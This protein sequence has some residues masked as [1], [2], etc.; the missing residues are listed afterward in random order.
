MPSPFVDVIPPTTIKPAALGEVHTLAIGWNGAVFTFTVDGADTVVDPRPFQAIGKATP[1][2]PDKMLGGLVTFSGPG[3]EAA[4]AGD[5][6]NVY[7]NGSLY[8]DFDGAPFSGPRLDPT[9]WGGDMLEHVRES[10]GGRLVSKAAAAG[11][12]GNA[13]GSV[14]RFVNQNAVT[15]IRADVTVTEFQST[16]SFA[17]AR[18][19][20]SVYNDGTGTPDGGFTGDVAGYLRLYSQNGSP[21]RV[22]FLVY[23]CTNAQCSAGTVLLDNTGPA[24][25]LGQT[26]TLLL[27]WDGSVFTYGI[28]GTP[29][30]F[31]PKPAVPPVKPPMGHFKALESVASVETPGGDGYIA[32]TYDNVYVNDDAVAVPQLAPFL[33]TA[34]AGDVTSAGVGLRGTGS[35]VINLAGIPAGATVQQ[36][37]LYWA[38]LGTAGT[39]TAPTL[40]GTAVNGT[41]IGR[42]DDTFWG[43]FQNY[44]YRADVT[45]LI[46]GNGTYTVSGLP[47]AGPT[48]NDSQGASL[49][50][51]YSVP[52]APNRHIHI[53]EGAV[54]LAGPRLAYYATRMSGLAAPD[55]PTGTTLTFLVGD[56]Q[57]YTGDS[58]GLNATLVATNGFNGSN[59]TYWDTRSYDVSG[60]LAGGATSADVVVS[61][62]NDSLVWVAAI[63][64]VPDHPQVAL[65]VSK[66]G[67]GSGTVTSDPAGIACGSTCSASFDVGT[68]VTLTAAALAGS[69]FAG[70]S[71]EGCSG[72][73]TCTVAVDQARHVTGTF[74]SASAIPITFGQTVA[75]SISSAGEQ[76]SY[77]FAAAAGDKVLARITATAGSLQPVLRLYAP[78]GTKPCEA[79]AYPAPTG[80]IASCAIPTAGTYTLLALDRL[81]TGTGS[82]SLYLQRLNGPGSPTA[83]TFGQTAAGTLASATQ[84]NTYA[85][86]AA[87]GDKVLARIT[88]TAGSLQ[89]VLRLYG[90]DGSKLCEAIAYPAPTGEIASCAIPT[91]GTYTLLALDRLGT[92]TGSYSLYLQRLNGPGSPTALTFGQTAAGTLASATQMNTYAFSAAAGDK[93]LARITATAGSLQPVLRLYAPDGSLVN[94]ATAYPAPTAELIVTL[95]TAGTYTLL[96]LDRLGTGTGS[97]SL[98]LQRLNGPGSPTPIVVGQTLS[99]S[100]ASTAE[101]NAF[102]FSVAA[103][104]TVLVRITATTGSLQ[105]VLRLYAPDGSLVNEATAYPAPT[106][107]LIVTLPTAGTYTLLALDRLGTGTGSYSLYLQRLNGP[108]SPTP[109]VVGQTLSSS[110]ASTAE[111][112]AFTFS[113][114]A[115][116]KVLARITATAGSLQPVLRLYAPDGSLVNEAT[117]YPAP[118]AELIVTL[119]TAGTYTLLALDRLG[120]GTGSYSLYLQRLNGPGSPTALTF[121]QTAAGTLASATQMNTYAFSAAAGDKVL[122]R[123][124]ATAGSLQP[125]LRLYGP[126][127]SKLCEAIA[128]PAPTGEIASCAIPTSGTYTLLALDRLGTGTGSYS[129]YLQRLNGPGSPTPIVVGQTLSSSI[130][131]TAEMNAFT[132]SVAANDTV[133]VRMTQTAGTLQPVVR[134]YGPDGSKLCEATAYPAPTAEIASCPLPTA[135]TYTLLALDRLGTGTGGY[136]LTLQNLEFQISTIFPNGGG[137]AG[138]VSVAINGHQLWPGTMVRLRRVGYSDILGVPVTVA[139]NGESLTTTFDLRGAEPGAWDV[140][141]TSADSKSATLPNGFTVASGGE[142]RLWAEV[143]AAPA[144]RMG[145][146]RFMVSYGNS[147]NIDSPYAW[148]EIALPGNVSYEV[149]IPPALTPIT[150]LGA[151]PAGTLKATLVHLS[152]LPANGTGYV[153]VKI[154]PAAIGQ[155]IPVSVAIEPR[156]KTYL[157]AITALQATNALDQMVEP[158]VGDPTVNCLP[159]CPDKWDRPEPPPAGYICRWDWT[160]QPGTYAVDG[161]PGTVSV[162]RGVHYAKSLGGNQVIEMWRIPECG[163]P[164][165]RLNSLDASNP[166]FKGCFKP[167]PGYDQNH[168]NDVLQRATNALA[169]WGSGGAQ[170]SDKPCSYLANNNT[171]V[172]DCIGFV[173]LLEKELIPLTGLGW[174]GDILAAIDHG[175]SGGYV[176]KLET[177]VSTSECPDAYERMINDAAIILNVVG[178]IDPNSKSGAAGYGPARFSSSGHG[179]SYLINFEN[180]AVATAPAQEVVITDQLDPQKV[181]FATFALGPIRF[182]T[183]EIV[184][185]RGLAL[186]YHDV[187]LRPG[188]NLLVRIAASLD[189]TNGLA[190]WRFTSI[191]P[192]TGLPPEDP[193]AGFLP[194]NMNSPEGEGSVLFTIMPKAGLPTGTE[195]R[196]KASIV[197]D[198]NAPI[199]TP[200]WLNTL[201]ND[202]PSSQVAA[203]PAV[204]AVTS[205]EVQW[206]GSDVGAGVKDYTIFVSENGGAFTEWLRNTT[207][208]SATF[209]GQPG[210]SYAFYSVARDQAGNVEDAPT[211]PDAT[212][213]IQAGVSLT[214]TTNPGGRQI[215][216]D[217]QSYTAPQT[218]TWLAGA[219]H[220]LGALSP[221]DGPAGTRYVF[222][223]WSDGGAQTHDVTVPASG[224]TVTVNFTTQYQ[225]TPAV[226]PPGSGSVLATPASA[227]GFYNSG[228]SIQI[229][230]SASPGYVFTGWSGDCAG[231]GNP[232]FLNMDAPRSAT[233]T[234]T[235]GLSSY[236]L[237]VTKAG[238]GSGTVT[239]V[240]AGINCGSTCTAP[241]NSGESVSLT[242]TPDNSV[243]DTAWTGCDS[244]SA[245]KRQCSVSMTQARSVTVTFGW[246]DDFESYTAGTFPSPAWTN[247]GNTA[248]VV[249]A[250]T[251]VAAT[252]G[253]KLFGV[254]GSCWGALAHRPITVQPGVVIEAYVRNG[255]ENLSGCH[256]SYGVVQ[257]NT[258][259]N[260]NTSG[261]ALLMFD[262]DDTTGARIVRGMTSDVPANGPN[263]GS[264]VQETWYKVKIRYER[265]APSTV[266]FSYWINDVFKGSYDSAALSYENDLAYL[267]LQ[268]AEGSAWFDNVKTSPAGPISALSVTKAGTGEGT[269]TSTPAGIDCGSTCSAPF[270]ENTAVTLTAT[271][272]TGSIFTGWS[273]DADCSDGTVTMAGARSC[274]ATFNLATTNRTGKIIVVNDDW[275][276]SNTG[277]AAPNDPGTF[278]TNVAAWFTGGRPGKFHA[279]SGHFGLTGSSLAAAMTTTTAGHTWTTGTADSVTLATLQPYD[280]IFLL[281]A[282]LEA[283]VD[284]TVLIAYVEAGGN[285]YLAYS[286]DPSHSDEQYNAF[287]THFGLGLGVIYNGILGNVAINSPHPIFAG[288]DSLYNNIGSDIVDLAPADPR[289]RVLVS[290]NGHGLYAVYEGNVPHTVGLFRPSDGTFYLDYKGNGVW[291]GCG[292]DRCLSIG[293]NGDIP[294]VGDWNGSGTSKVGAFRPSDGTFYLDYNG[295]GDWDGCGTDRCLQIGMNGDIPLGRRL[296]RQRHEQGGRLPSERRHVLP[297]LQRERDLGRLR[298]GS[299]SSDRDERRYSPGRRLEWLWHEQGGRLPALGWHL[300]PRP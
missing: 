198:T 46:L 284:T 80:E 225:L 103:N 23:R 135:G 7:V 124:T 277:F 126:D 209:T 187:D 214:V 167:Y 291:D 245:D 76:D 164:D 174:I 170:W 83:L 298:D 38:T 242:A 9:K 235:T 130:A 84:M 219:T 171:L 204:Q 109:I 169:L 218:F 32:A 101:M 57:T 226:S 199:E 155:Q 10:A 68:S 142:A 149:E 55:P 140:L 176:D 64:S 243:A 192:N 150:P 172:S 294:L 119:P 22:N 56:G 257:F 180:V 1:N 165:L 60:A 42:S 166:A 224:T 123:I 69:S 299:V 110:I 77:I 234:F 152:T 260:W 283:P 90:P 33:Q 17:Q 134:L 148:L 175:G 27:A 279:F 157:E 51:I 111:M 85:F 241:F 162:P 239:S 190:T 205:F 98:Y 296:E 49:V 47:H 16:G 158:Q 215:I 253:L 178:S 202:K 19:V 249:E 300:L 252:K 231:Q 145:E 179:A 213:A 136:S 122:A 3:G 138:A 200:E 114:A 288:V 34:V 62:A 203:L 116:D 230:P 189:T 223:A 237:T 258:G 182:G 271:P 66:A 281:P 104:D 191:D 54:T 256:S 67:L 88:A 8:D 211:G 287:V 154:T 222:A 233:G 160:Q 29:L 75:G 163:V 78:D 216:V 267:S 289:Q 161:C 6:D 274:T 117:A 238:T 207:A 286:G 12:A 195:I 2:V 266:R 255:A 193:M 272:T 261:R 276:L 269:V 58:A 153:T 28:D 43:A 102:T 240:P 201:D 278:A 293:M 168:A 97:Y 220:T 208:T 31:D 196:N 156:G 112:N 139:A 92:G 292:I 93:V 265:M 79:I 282:P 65:T 36:A 71:G 37:F 40:N 280:G 228:T 254:L 99:S 81:G 115:G 44:A 143:V 59:G 262:Q 141:V 108:G 72:T 236:P 41:L 73:G 15:A 273:G 91:S 177:R 250:G 210:K 259:P 128:Y 137:N 131:S 86:S 194:P 221:Q 173:H 106:A 125:V 45:A 144:I 188:K 270:D 247:S 184:P 95:P 263:L 147:G 264:Y 14:A 13:M 232:C 244:V 206:S 18:L 275:V 121:G 70:W 246:F 127:G 159:N 132:F 297:R 197:F 24:V 186:F 113:A 96:A 48:V 63:L 5:F 11:A 185:P 181:D 20:G 248:A 87:A 100:I 105:P 61:T 285:V 151:A 129:L 183:T 133:L 227:D 53:N 21:L 295:N 26:Y 74:N 251:G 4:S 39:F 50:V 35:G 118:T 107:E 229:T 25:N 30:T 94:E 82:Y 89:P 146:S 268:S 212:T 217:S 52:G 290:Q 120:T